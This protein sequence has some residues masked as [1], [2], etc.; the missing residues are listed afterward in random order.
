[1]IEK[2]II[3]CLDTKDGRLVKGT[4]FVNLVDIGD[5]IEYAKMY[6]KQGASE[7]VFLDITATNEKRDTRIELVKRGAEAVNI[8]IAIGGGIKSIEDIRRILNSGASKVSI[9]SA[10]VKNPKLIEEACCE[11]GKERIVIAID[12]GKDEAGKFTVRISGGEEDT[13]LD[14]VEWAKEC[15]R[16]GAGEILLTSLDRDGTKA[17]YDIE[18]TKAVSENVSIPVIASG[19]CGNISDIV[20]VFQET[21]CDAAL[22]A[23]LLHY[24]DSTIDKIKEELG[25]NQINVRGKKE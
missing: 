24:E 19:G 8:P 10:A 2:R 1:M 14:I 21:N 5:P 12:G 16:L 20:E 7:I 22:V 25:K 15:E 6:E 18:M 9:N 17:G 13:G 11:F 23:S 4:N 3:P